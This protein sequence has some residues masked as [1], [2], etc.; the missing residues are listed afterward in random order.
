MRKSSFS[1]E[2]IIKILKEKVA[3]AT[4]ADLCRRHGISEQTSTAGSRSSAVLEVNDARRLNQLE[5]EAAEA[6]GCRSDAWTT[7]R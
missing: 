1:K 4:L 6:P 5:D 2:Q 7:R 3:G